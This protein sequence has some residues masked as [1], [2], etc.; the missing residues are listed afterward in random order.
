[1]RA[2]YL[3]GQSIVRLALEH[4]VGRGAIGTTVADLMSEHTASHEDDPT[5]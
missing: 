2:A 3:G 5:P 4:D 1:V